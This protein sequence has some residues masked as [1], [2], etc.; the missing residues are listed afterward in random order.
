MGKRQGSPT[1][2]QGPQSALTCRIADCSPGLVAEPEEPE[3]LPATHTHS[4]PDSPCGCPQPWRLAS[5][6]G[7]PGRGRLLKSQVPLSPDFST[8]SLSHG[9]GRIWARGRS[10]LQCVKGPSR[11][12][13][14]K[15]QPQSVLSRHQPFI[16]HVLFATLSAWFHPGTQRTVAHTCV[17]LTRQTCSG[18]T[19]AAACVTAHHAGCRAGPVSAGRSCGHLCLHLVKFQTKS[20]PKGRHFSLF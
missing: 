4:Y 19:A 2:A 1:G 10:H 14:E 6:L 5:T 15:A 3:R 12:E 18:A 17:C 13:S 8:P 11:R 9:E 16:P 7:L 20:I